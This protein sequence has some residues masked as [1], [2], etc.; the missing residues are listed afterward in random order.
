MGPLILNVI[1]GAGCI[2]LACKALK[3]DDDDLDGGS[4]VLA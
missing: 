3:D 2:L 4:Y 1:I